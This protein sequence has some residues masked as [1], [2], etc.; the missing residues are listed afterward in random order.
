M[1]AVRTISCTPEE[2]TAM[3]SYLKKKNYKYDVSFNRDTEH[4]EFTYKL[5]ED[6]YTAVLN[7]LKEL[8]DNTDNYEYFDTLNVAIGAV[9]TLL[10]MEVLK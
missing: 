4:F 2:Y 3:T 10:D 9:K 7:D 8:Q 1:K 6:Y 5:E